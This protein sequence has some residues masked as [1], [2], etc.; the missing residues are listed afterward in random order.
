MGPRGVVE[1]L[2]ADA[3]V[4]AAQTSGP[5]LRRRQVRVRGLQ[6]RRHGDVLHMMRIGQMSPFSAN[7]SGGSSEAASTTLG[8]ETG[9]MAAAAAAAAMAAAWSGRRLECVRCHRGRAPLRERGRRRFMRSAALQVRSNLR[10]V[11][12]RART[13]WPDRGRVA[14]VW[15]GRTRDPGPPS[16]RPYEG[17]RDASFSIRV[18]SH[19]RRASPL[20]VTVRQVYHIRYAEGHEPNST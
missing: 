18:R 7:G 1:A 20:V 13:A 2:P 5:G 6:R 9:G 4:L 19:R 3:A 16:R 8:S 14:R 17:I 11:L 15:R 12:G 10:W